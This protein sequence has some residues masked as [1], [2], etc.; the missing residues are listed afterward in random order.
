M[1]S[2]ALAVSTPNL[3]IKNAPLPVDLSSEFGKKKVLLS[4]HTSAFTHVC[5]HVYI[6]SDTTPLSCHV[7]QKKIAFNLNA[8]TSSQHVSPSALPNLFLWSSSIGRKTVRTV[9]DVHQNEPF[10]MAERS[11]RVEN[12][13][14]RATR[15]YTEAGIEQATVAMQCHGANS[16]EP[17]RRAVPE[18]TRQ[19]CAQQTRQRCAL[20]TSSYAP[21]WPEFIVDPCPSEESL[22]CPACQPPFS[23]ILR[24]RSLKFRVS[25]P[26]ICSPPVCITRSVTSLSL[27]TTTCTPEHPIFFS[28]WRRPG[29]SWSKRRLWQKVCG[30]WGRGIGII[31]TTQQE[32]TCSV[33]R[34]VLQTESGSIFK[35]VCVRVLNGRVKVHTNMCE[36][37]V[38]SANRR[39]IF[40]FIFGLAS[41]DGEATGTFKKILA[42]TL[43][44]A[45]ESQSDK[46]VLA[47]KNGFFFFF[48]TLAC[49]ARQCGA[50]L[51][52]NEAAAELFYTRESRKRRVNWEGTIAKEKEDY[53]YFDDSWRRLSSPLSISPSPSAFYEQ[54]TLFQAFSRHRGRDRWFRNSLEFGAGLLENTLEKT[55]STL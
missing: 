47:R 48:F 51:I 18:R 36:P 3:V 13:L 49:C 16:P 26:C 22:C 20:K 35:K 33:K 19:R 2:D 1:S 45:L 39:L 12:F 42:E 11:E 46:V 30:C 27:A 6:C 24:P 54:N 40:G 43:L 23:P 41:S 44:L 10:S 37:K 14:F 53:L 32:K 5:I 34:E 7:Y 38:C 17:S 9:S 25:F 29:Q 50:G 15:E 55:K 52:I 28:T 8:Y 21:P 4:A 31:M